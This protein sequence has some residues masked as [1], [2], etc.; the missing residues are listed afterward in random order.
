V[1]STRNVIY[2]INILIKLIYKK[3]YKKKTACP[4]S[5]RVTRAPL[6]YL[7]AGDIGF[8]SGWG[9]L[10]SVVA[11][12]G[13]HF[14]ACWPLVSSSP[15]LVCG[16]PPS[17]ASSPRSCP[18]RRTLP[19]PPLMLLAAPRPPLPLSP[20]LARIHAPSGPRCR[21]CY[22]CSCS[23]VAASRAADVVAVV[24]VVARWTCPSR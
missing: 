4:T 11:L 23:S 15:A 24:A 16:S 8:W 20:L 19:H 17:F 12:G 2:K 9:P 13:G 21:C 5:A 3:K 1:V 18:G 6:H 14:R 22:C 10:L 7:P